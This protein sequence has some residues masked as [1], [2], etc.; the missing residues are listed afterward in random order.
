MTSSSTSAN[1]ETINNDGSLEVTYKDGST[2]SVEQADDG[3]YSFIFT[4]SDSIKIDGAKCVVDA[5]VAVPANF[6]K[7]MATVTHTE[8]LLFCR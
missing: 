6:V 2:L 4:S 7:Q 8:G 5:T 1:S 3:T